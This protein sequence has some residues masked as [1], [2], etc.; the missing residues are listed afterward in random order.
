MSSD[1]NTNTFAQLNYHLPANPQPH[2]DPPSTGANL[3]LD[4]KSSGKRPPFSSQGSAGTLPH[5]NGNGASQ[6]TR[7]GDNEAERFAPPRNIPKVG[8]VRSKPSGGV[9]IL[10]YCKFQHLLPSVFYV[11]TLTYSKSHMN[12]LLSFSA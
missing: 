12:C 2:P 10:I 6:I 8:G 1:P 4:G 11:R 7:A 3:S 9:S 5:T